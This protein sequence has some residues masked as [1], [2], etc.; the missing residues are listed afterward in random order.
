MLAG[1]VSAMTSRCH[2]TSPSRRRPENR[3]RRYVTGRKGSKRGRKEAG[4][5]GGGGGIPST[6]SASSR[7]RWREHRALGPMG[8][9]E[10]CSGG[11]SA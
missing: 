9:P 8:G 7:A 3:W 10:H 5:G 2:W 6:V 4:E 11:R 1:K